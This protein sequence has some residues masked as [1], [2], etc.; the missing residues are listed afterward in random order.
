MKKMEKI[1]LLIIIIVI[2]II[3]MVTV[4]LKINKKA[5]DMESPTEKISYEEQFNEENKIKKIDSNQDYF[6]VKN[7]IENYKEISNNWNNSKKNNN[8]QQI[9]I[10]RK[11]IKAII[12][13][14]VTQNMGE[15]IYDKVTLKHNMVRIDSIY[16]S[17][18][19]I[20][21]Q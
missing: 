6:D 16:K 5:E 8:E 11:E 14:F 15:D 2:I 3:V 17:I 9:E 7:C 20:S 4:L 19:T 18:Q 10:A 13:D 12:P 21:K 1:I